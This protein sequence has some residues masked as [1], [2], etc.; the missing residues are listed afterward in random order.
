MVSS[1]RIVLVYKRRADEYLKV[2]I[3]RD[4]QIVTSGIP[5]AS[6]E[7]HCAETLDVLDCQLSNDDF[8]TLYSLKLKA[9]L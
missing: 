2:L 3:W 7:T 9:G 1:L 6:S 5:R 4:I 8:S